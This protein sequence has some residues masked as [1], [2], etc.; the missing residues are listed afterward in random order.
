MRIHLISVATLLAVLLLAP[1][2]VQAQGTPVAT[3]SAPVYGYRVLAEYPHDPDAFTQG[4]EYIDGTLYEGTGL[5]GQSTLRRVD[6]ET[7]KVLQ[8][9]TLNEQLFGEG[10]AV[11]DDHIY[12]LTWKNLIAIQFDRD[13]F[14]PI[15]TFRNPVEGW[16]LTYDGERLIASDG[17]NRLYFRDPET[18]AELGSI[19]VYDG[20][21]PVTELNELEYIDGEIWA[22]IW[23]ADRIARID[24]A[25][26]KVNSWVDLTGLLSRKDRRGAEVDVLNGIAYDA[27]GGRIFV[28]G[29][30][31]PK[32]FVIEVVEE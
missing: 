15:Q 7:G 4:L 13:T 29:K 21:T 22:N 19:D 3:T 1:M 28:T 26:G 24:P 8:G 5:N 17:T 32:L 16:G 9:V 31:W 2:L 10:I 23:Q 18:F 14:E 6:L 20:E 30:L 25:S 27:D 12:Q 11:V